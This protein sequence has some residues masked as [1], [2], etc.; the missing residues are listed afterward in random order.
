MVSKIAIS[1]SGELSR[2]LE[3]IAKERGLSRSRLIEICLRENP[4]IIKEISNYQLKE[5]NTC[6]KCKIPFGPNDIR[7]DT[8]KYGVICKNCWSSEMGKIVEEHPISN[9]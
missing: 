4:S 3:K 9:I 8:P 5:A 6:E 1:I 2:T 7:I